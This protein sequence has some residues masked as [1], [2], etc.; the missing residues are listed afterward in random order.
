MSALNW[1]RAR[2]GKTG[3][4]EYNKLTAPVDGAGQP[5]AGTQTPYSIE[6]AWREHLAPAIRDLG[7]KG[8]GRN[9]RLITDQFALAVNLQGS[10]HGGKF[11]INLGIHPLAIPIVNGKAIDIKSFRE[12]ECAFRERLTADGRDT[13]WSYA[14]DAPSIRDAAQNAASLFRANAMAQFNARMNFALSATPQTVGR[15]LP[16]TL[17]SFALLREAQGNLAQAKAFAHLARKTAMSSWITPVSLRHLI[18]E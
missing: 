7:F 10:R 1:I 9:Y 2:L 6:Y 16:M 11:A 8:S 13:W 15:V 5:D 17:V 4:G 12:V 3:T 14:D 18:G